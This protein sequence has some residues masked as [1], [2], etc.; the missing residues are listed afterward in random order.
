[1]IFTP[2]AFMASKN[3]PTDIPGL[4]F[5]F[6]ANSTDYTQVG[7]LGTWDDSS[8][9]GN[10]LTFLGAGTSATALDTTLGYDA[11]K[12]EGSVT[13]GVTNT[14]N[15]WSSTTEVTNIEIIRPIFS[16]FLRSTFGLQGTN[17][18]SSMPP[19]SQ[20]TNKIGVLRDSQPDTGAFWRLNTSYNSSTTAFIARRIDTGFNNTS[21]LNISY[22]DDISVPLTHYGPG[23]F[24]RDTEMASGVSTY[25]LGTS[26]YFTL[27]NIRDSASSAR[28]WSGYYMASLTYNRILT[29]AEIEIIY[30]Y[31][32][33]T[34]SLT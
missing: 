4:V 9:N 13:R 23:S 22:G 20:S 32:K 28:C 14:V 15:N 6:E 3:T 7:G 8:G 24:T 11:V 27:A 12:V 31:Y 5:K 30:N 33:S 29:E 25:S 10:D 21:N 1:M 17:N 16:G 18:V 19:T 26:T 34:Y 2:F